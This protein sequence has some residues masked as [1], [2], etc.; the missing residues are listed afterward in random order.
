[1]CRARI[2]AHSRARHF[3]HQLVIEQRRRHLLASAHQ[4]SVVGAAC[5]LNI[6]AI[7]AVF[8][9]A[10][11]L[12]GADCLWVALASVFFAVS[13]DLPRSQLTNRRTRQASRSNAHDRCKS[14]AAYERRFCCLRL[15]QKH[16]DRGA[17]IE[18]ATGENTREFT[19]A[20]FLGNL[21]LPQ[22]RRPPSGAR[23]FIVPFCIAAFGA[24]CSSSRKR[25]LRT[26]IDGCKL[27]RLTTFDVGEQV[28]GGREC[29]S[30][31]AVEFGSA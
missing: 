31:S 18:D 17:S 15:D 6:G 1:M 8:R 21:H 26:L 2:A 25:D 30:S 14:K 7:V 13:V 9:L 10:E 3:D 23:R 24:F 4:R 19:L 20:Q 12:S 27:T 5:A 22:Q 11:R 29:G 28:V 16:F